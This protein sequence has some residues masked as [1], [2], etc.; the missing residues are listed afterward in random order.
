VFLRQR[1][2]CHAKIA[3]NMGIQAGERVLDP[4]DVGL[5]NRLNPAD[6]NGVLDQEKRRLV[7]RSHGSK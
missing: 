1:R 4:G 2:Q 3:I 7:S 5:V 6:S